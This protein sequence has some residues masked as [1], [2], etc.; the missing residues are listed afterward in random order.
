M[1]C[2][3]FSVS[4]L[5]KLG[6]SD[7]GWWLMIAEYG[8]AEEADGSGRLRLVFRRGLFYRRFPHA[9]IDFNGLEEPCRFLKNLRWFEKLNDHGNVQVT[10][11]ADF[12][13]I[14]W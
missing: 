14:T 4:G 5:G 11:H 8:E 9:K 1:L 2:K 12:R 13:W 7:V 3:D 10:G 6:W